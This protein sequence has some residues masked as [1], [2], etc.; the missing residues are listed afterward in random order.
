MNPTIY[1]QKKRLFL[2]FN[3]I[4]P[5]DKNDEEITPLKNKCDQVL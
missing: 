5:V 2:L 3:K 4:L 1:A